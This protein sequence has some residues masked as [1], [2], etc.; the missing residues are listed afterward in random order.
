MK[1]KLS[2]VLRFSRTTRILLAIFVVLVICVVFMGLDNVTG[3]ATGW[4]AT[5]VLLAIL[6]Y[7]WRK[8]RYFLILAVAAFVGSI[9]LAFLHEE[10]VYPLTGWIGGTGAMNSVPLNIYHQVTSYLIFFLGPMGIIGGIAGALVLS[11]FRVKS[12]IS[13]KKVPEN[14]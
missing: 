4:L 5:L 11:Y 14:T 12:L 1:K 10:V 3:L 6:T 2:A 13:T 7:R 8:I 9:L